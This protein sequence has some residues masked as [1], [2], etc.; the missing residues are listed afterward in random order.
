MLTETPVGLLVT[1]LS[2]TTPTD[3]SK[4]SRSHSLRVTG[5]PLASFSTYSREAG[6]AVGSR[7]DWASTLE[8]KGLSHD[9]G[10]DSSGV[11]G[12][13]MFAS[14]VPSTNGY[15]QFQPRERLCRGSPGTPQMLTSAAIRT[16]ACV[17]LR[18]RKVTP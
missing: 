17:M 3:G 11:S 9:V 4:P 14:H 16:A 6:R 12:T 15:A 8:L 2:G 18:E 5:A 7:H 10:S 13:R 1:W